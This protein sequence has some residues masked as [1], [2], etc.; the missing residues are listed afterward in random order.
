MKGIIKLFPTL[1]PTQHFVVGC[2]IKY[3]DLI[4]TIKKVHKTKLTLSTGKLVSKINCKLMKYYI[5]NNNIK[6][7]LNYR[8]YD[9]VHDGDKFEYTKQVIPNKVEI[10]DIIV[11]F[12]PLLHN[13][14]KYQFKAQQ[15]VVTNINGRKHTISING[16]EI[17]DVRRHR[18]KVISRPDK[19]VICTIIE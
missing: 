6:G 5:V 7:E 15:G 11:L 16:E 3:D 13:L 12:K 9:K 1:N 14:A 8:Q 19:R 18:F 10:G 17:E 2:I 4:Y